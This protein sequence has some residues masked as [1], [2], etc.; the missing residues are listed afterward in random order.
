M[1]IQHYTANQNF[2]PMACHVFALSGDPASIGPIN[3]RYCKLGDYLIGVTPLPTGA[4]PLPGLTTVTAADIKGVQNSYPA[5]RGQAILGIL[6]KEFGFTLKPGSGVRLFGHIEPNQ[7]LPEHMYV[8]TNTGRIYDTLPG[9][10]IRRNNNNNG[11]NP[12]SY[13]SNP[14]G[15]DVLQNSGVVFSVEVSVLAAGTQ[16]VISSPDSSWA[17]G[18]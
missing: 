5:A 18:M 7:W 1:P 15:S 3:D 8:T 16:A 9:A 6:C 13:G 10:S 11:L 4:E 2:L 14:D 12:P 17:A